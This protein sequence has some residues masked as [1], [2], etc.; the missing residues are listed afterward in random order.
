MQKNAKILRQIMEN[1]KRKAGKTAKIQ[2][3]DGAWFT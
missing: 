2:Q 3:F 1:M